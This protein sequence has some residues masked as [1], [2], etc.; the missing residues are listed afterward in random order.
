MNDDKKKLGFKDY[1]A[2]IIALLETQLLPLI[3]L[4]LLIIILT[5]IFEYIIK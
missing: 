5:I 1:I 2:F 4:A 3:L